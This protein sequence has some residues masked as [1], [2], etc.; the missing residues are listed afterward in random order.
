MKFSYLV[1]EPVTDLA[2][3]TRRMRRVAELGYDGIELTATHPLGF[4]IDELVATSQEFGL[5]VVSLLS[6]WS[7][8]NEG[9]CLSSPSADVRQQTVARLIEYI[10]L[11]ERLGA[12]LVVGLLQGLRAD[13]PNEQLAN[14]RIAESLRQVARVAE[15]KRV[16][17]V[18]EPVNHLQ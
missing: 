2:E 13:E 7:Y 12:L 4:S 15:A 6:G 8:A 5:P 17:I 10:A 11:A 14:Q 18:V 1:Y 3:L 9:L 16:S